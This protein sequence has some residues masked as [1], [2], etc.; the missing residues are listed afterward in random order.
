MGSGSSTPSRFFVRNDS[1]INCRVG[2]NQVTQRKV[3]E[4]NQTGVSLDAGK[5][6]SNVANADTPA[7]KAVGVLSAMK[8][9]NKKALSLN[10][11]RDNTTFA[12]VGRGKML[13]FNLPSG[14]D[15]EIFVS[16]TTDVPPGEEDTA[17]VLCSDYSPPTERSAAMPPIIII[18][19]DRTISL[20]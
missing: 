19:R 17:V 9:S 2:V 4:F 15:S 6:I 8:V 12:V 16:I 1:D 5:A 7:Q 18:D 20:K 3:S 14:K 13:A 10:F 11:V